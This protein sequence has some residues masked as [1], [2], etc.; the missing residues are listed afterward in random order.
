MLGTALVAS[1]AVVLA[2]GTATAEPT[3]G[4]PEHANGTPPAYGYS[5]DTPPGQGTPPGLTTSP[6]EPD[7]PGQAV[8]SEHLGNDEALGNGEAV[9]AHAAGPADLSAAAAGDPPGNNGTVK[10]HDIDISDD[11]HRTTPKV[12]EFRIVGF[13]FDSGQPLT[14]SIEGAPTPNG[15]TGSYSASIVAGTDGTFAEAVPTLPD[16]NYRVTLY[17]GVGGGEKHKNLEVDCTPVDEGIASGGADSAVAGVSVS[18]DASAVDP[19]AGQLP[20]TGSSV[21]DL[22]LIG[23][24]ALGVGLILWGQWSARRP[25][26]GLTA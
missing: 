21:R 22:L 26:H 19:V 15:G 8:R 23:V 4:G 17:T 6:A 16:G 9:D 18:S 2:I 24:A 12:C 25:R 3:N 20:N 11:D 13:G 1:S 10:V 5:S 7:P 14:L